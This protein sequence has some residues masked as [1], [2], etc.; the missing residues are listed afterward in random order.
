MSIE[1]LTAAFKAEVKNSPAKFVLVALADYANEVGEAYPSISTLQK[2]TE[3]NRKTVIKHLKKL[4]GLGFISD[5]AERKGLTKQVKVWKLH[6]LEGE[7]APNSGSLDDNNNEPEN[8]TVSQGE[9]STESGTVKEAQKGDSS[10]NGTVPNLPDNNPES[11]TVKGSQKR[12]TDPSVLLTL[13]DPSDTARAEVLKNADPDH[14]LTEQELIA[15]KPEEVHAQ[16]W[17]SFLKLRKRRKAEVT[18]RATIALL[19]SLITCVHHGVAMNDMIQT[20][21]EKGWK[22]VN[23]EW[24]LNLQAVGASTSQSQPAGKLTLPRDNEQ[25]E[26]FAQQNGLPGPG[27]GESWSQYR[28]RLTQFIERQQQESHQE[29]VNA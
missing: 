16:L 15:C 17:E 5:T 19:K 2:K 27:R 3:Q 28:H 14:Q 25:L 24:Y 6:L 21:L 22:G 8:G 13:T 1:Y 10:K 23:V 11:G 18:V 7:T 20:C 9:N 29:V 26:R 12:Y 4:E